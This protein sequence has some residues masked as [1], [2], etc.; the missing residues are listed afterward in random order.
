MLA[1]NGNPPFHRLPHETVLH[2]TDK[3]ISLSIESGKDLPVGDELKKTITCPA[4]TVYLT[5]LRVIP[6]LP[7][8]IECVDCISPRET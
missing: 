4:G 5:N 2:T 7:N 1:P 3:T 6:I 8:I